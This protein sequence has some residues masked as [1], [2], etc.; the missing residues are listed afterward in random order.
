FIFAEKLVDNY[1]EAMLGFSFQMEYIIREEN[2]M[3]TQEILELFCELIVVLLPIIETQR[4]VGKSLLQFQ[5]TTRDVLLCH[6]V[7]I[8]QVLQLANF[9]FLG[10]HKGSKSA[11]TC[12]M[13]P[14]FFT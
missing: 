10:V 14:H 11:Q 12:K 13:S 6:K 9:G 1:K 3:A 8:L 4:L 2:M 5:F 7:R